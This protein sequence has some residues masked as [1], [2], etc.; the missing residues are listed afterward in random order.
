[1]ELEKVAPGMTE[2]EHM[3]SQTEWTTQWQKPFGAHGTIAKNGLRNN[4]NLKLPKGGPVYEKVKHLLSNHLYSSVYL[5][6]QGSRI[7]ISTT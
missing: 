5:Y 3:K 4:R 6:S 1:M 7:P 2:L